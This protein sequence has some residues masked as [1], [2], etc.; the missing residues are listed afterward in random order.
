MFERLLRSHTPRLYKQK[1][2]SAI[3]YIQKGCK[4]SDNALKLLKDKNIKIQKYI[5][6][7]DKQL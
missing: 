7:N 6:N 5:V 1:S 4:F 2:K 3:I